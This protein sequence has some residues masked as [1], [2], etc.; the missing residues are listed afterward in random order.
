L[1]LSDVKYGLQ[2]ITGNQ[3]HKWGDCRRSYRIPSSS[4]NTLRTCKP[5]K[6][7]SYFCIPYSTEP[8]LG[9]LENAPEMIQRPPFGSQPTFSVAYFNIFSHPASLSSPHPLDSTLSHTMCNRGYEGVASCFITFDTT[10]VLTHRQYVVL[11]KMY[12]MARF[13]LATRG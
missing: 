8:K 5:C 11:R 12:E 6:F 9:K 13:A 2:T 4:K 1:P 3:I 10:I 7:S